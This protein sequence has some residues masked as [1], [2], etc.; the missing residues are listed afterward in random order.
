MVLV[1]SLT[2]GWIFSPGT[3]RCELNIEL[4]QTGNV[5]ECNAFPHHKGKG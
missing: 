5:E 1:R 2:I 3:F 4:L